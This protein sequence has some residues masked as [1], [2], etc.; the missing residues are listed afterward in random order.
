[1][2]ALHPGTLLHGRTS[3][4]VEE[5]MYAA[6]EAGFHSLCVSSGYRDYDTQAQI[7]A[8]TPDKSLVQAP[9]HSEHQTGLAVDIVVLDLSQDDMASSPAGR[10][11]AKNSWQHGL[12]LR[13]APDKQALT[14]IASEPWHF[15]YVGQPHAWYCWQNNLCLEE[16]LDFLEKSGGYSAT[17]DGVRYTVVYERPEKG[18]IPTPAD[19]DFI[20]SSDNMGGYIVT[21]WE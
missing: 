9:N 18:S 7:Y 5:L 3:R 21:K 8:E 19:S 12:I 17:L 15:R 6:F 10:W 13:Y 14:H 4:A 1:V 16:Y 11:L 20:V 2:E